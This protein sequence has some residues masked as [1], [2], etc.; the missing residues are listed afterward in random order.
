MV[1]RQQT[2]KERQLTLIN[3]ELTSL[4]S[5]QNKGLV[6]AN[7]I[8]ALERELARLEGER[9][10]LTAQIAGK[11][12]EIGE[13]HLRIIQIDKNLS[14]EIITDLRETQAKAAELTEKRI[15]A[16]IRLRRTE[17]RAPQSGMIHQLAVH[18]LG[19]VV[20]A[21]EP[22]MFIVPEQDQLIFEAHVSPADIDQVQ[23][24]QKANIRLHAFD[25]GVFPE[26]AGK[27]ILISPD[28]INDARTHAPS[29][30]RSPRMS[31]WRW[32]SG[33]LCRGCWA[34]PSSRPRP[35]RCCAIC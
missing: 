7:R 29:A 35:I 17:I 1:L 10:A 30:S 33:C 24:G 34:R 32:G 9:G 27:V 19:G 31:S 18:T 6:R 12:G 13:T 22:L 16:E 26:I 28:S 20:A 4:K 11:R 8:L 5:L 2:S 14:S 15:A 23:I 25:P 21:G 3:N